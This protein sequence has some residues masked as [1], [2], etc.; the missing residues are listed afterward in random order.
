MILYMLAVCVRDPVNVSNTYVYVLDV[1]V[2]I[3]S[4]L[5]V[6]VCMPLHT[7]EIR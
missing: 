1:S 4:M 3:S 7:L 2:Y 6:T 5:H